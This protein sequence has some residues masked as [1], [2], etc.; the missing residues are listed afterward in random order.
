[1]SQYKG[2]ISNFAGS[3]IGRSSSR[4]SSGTTIG[5][6]GSLGG[7]A[8]M[9]GGSR[10]LIVSQTR[11]MSQSRPGS[12]RLSSV[13]YGI[14]GLSGNL[15]L[16]QAQRSHVDLTAPLPTIDCRQQVIRVEESRQIKGLNDQFAGFIGV[17]RTLEQKNKKLEIQLKLLKEQGAYTSNIDNMFQT[18]IENLKRQLELLGQEK[19]KFEADLVQMQGLVEDFKGKY[20]DEINKR[21]EMENEFVLVKKDVDESYMNKV[22]LEA[23]LESLTDEI[24]FLQS[25]FDEEIRELQAQIQNTAVSVQ[26][27]G[28]PGLNTV[29]LIAE[30]KEKYEQ[31]ANANRQQAA[32]WRQSKTQ[33]LSMSSGQYGDELGMM[34]E[35]IKNMN[36]RIRGL[37]NDIENLRNQRQVLEARIKDAEERGEL[38]LK[39]AKVKIAELDDAIANAGKQ[40]AK[41][42]QEY[43]ALAQIKMALVIEIATYDSLLQGEEKR[44][45]EG[46]RTLN[47]QQIQGQ[48]NVMGFSNMSGGLE[49][50]LGSGSSVGM[51]MGMGMGSSSGSSGQ[52]LILK[53]VEQSS[54]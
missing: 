45:Q 38:S 43:E 26:L 52:T 24:N 23:K 10:S 40:M 15:G 48:A 47:I 21:T 19:L 5:L 2:G 44:M 1:M 42:V 29:E 37:N 31:L 49:S 41:Q 30:A 17:V 39:E 11:Q 32:V 14:G 36:M 4:Y 8:R 27:A 13:G 51:G 18:Y 22:E 9:R 33:E 35:E 3:S 34:R 12:G 46:V 6:G 20:E 7:S 28:G 53:K 50:S 16:G 54:Y 25:I